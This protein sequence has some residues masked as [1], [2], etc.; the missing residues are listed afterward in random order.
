[1]WPS[2]LYQ[3]LAWTLINILNMYNMH[4]K[5]EEKILRAKTGDSSRFFKRFF[6]VEIGSWPCQ[7]M[8]FL[9]PTKIAFPVVE[10]FLRVVWCFKI[11][12]TL[13]WTLMNIL[14]MYNM[15]EKCE[16]KILRANT[17]ASSRFQKSFFWHLKLALGYVS[18]CFF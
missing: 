2:N 11:Y 18:L 17:G 7:R 4:K 3:T 9:N 14:H 15:H 6:T 12:Q 1:V 10:S 8:L 5:S 16:Y 13:A